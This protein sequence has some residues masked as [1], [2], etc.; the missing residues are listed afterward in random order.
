MTV[1]LRPQLQRGTGTA[2]A[3]LT[4]MQNGIEI[5]KTAGGIT[6]DTVGIDTGHLRRHVRSHAHQASCRLIDEF[7]G[8]QFQIGTGTDQQ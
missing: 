3:V 5:T 1:Q 4:G 7:E 6:A 8:I 2:K